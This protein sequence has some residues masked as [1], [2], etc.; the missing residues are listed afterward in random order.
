MP[1]HYA[2]SGVKGMLNR[3]GRVQLHKTRDTVRFGGWNCDRLKFL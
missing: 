1:G 3:A 2:D